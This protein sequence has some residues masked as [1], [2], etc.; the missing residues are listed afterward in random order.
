MSEKKIDII[1]RNNYK[2]FTDTY[3]NNSK[4]INAIADT[5][6]VIKHLIIIWD[7]FNF[8]QN[9]KLYRKRVD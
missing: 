3:F 9:L 5:I 6:E 8:I 2:N 1:N 4:S 7:T